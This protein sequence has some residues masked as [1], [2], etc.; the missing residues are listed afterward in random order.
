MRNSIKLKTESKDLSKCKGIPC[1]WTEKFNI[2]EISIFPDVIYSQYNPFQH[3][4]KL[5]CIHSYQQ[6][7]SKVYLERQKVQK[8]QHTTEKQSWNIDTKNVKV[9]YKL[10]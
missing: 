6:T 2:V 3:P 5:F 8:S 7:H 4:R 1:T 10:Q 9:Y